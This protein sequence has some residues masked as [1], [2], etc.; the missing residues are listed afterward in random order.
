MN[1]DPFFDY[2]PDG[3]VAAMLYLYDNGTIYA[4]TPDAASV[5]AAANSIMSKKIYNESN[6]SAET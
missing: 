3:S 1:D 6:K 5:V 2:T 4:H